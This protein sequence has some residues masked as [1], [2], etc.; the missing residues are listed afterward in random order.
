MKT[1]HRLT[2]GRS[3]EHLR[4]LFGD[5]SAGTGSSGGGGTTAH[6]CEAFTTAV[7]GELMTGLQ[8][9]ATF[10]D[11]TTQTAVWVPGAGGSQQGQANGTNWFLSEIGDTQTGT[12]TLSNT[13]GQGITKLEIVGGDVGGEVIFDTTLGSGKTPGSGA[14]QTF[15]VTGGTSVATVSYAYS[16]LVA[17]P[18]SAPVGDLFTTLTINFTSGGGLLTGTTLEF[19]A[20]TDLCVDYGAFGP[21]ETPILI[22]HVESELRTT[23]VMDGIGICAADVGYSAWG[24][25]IDSKDLATYS[26]TGYL[27]DVCYP[28]TSGTGRTTV[29]INHSAS[30][31]FCKGRGFLQGNFNFFTRTGQYTYAVFFRNASGHFPF[32]NDGTPGSSGLAIGFGNPSLDSAGSA[33]PTYIIGV[34]DGV[35][36]ETGPQLTALTGLLVVTYDGHASGA[37]NYYLA[38][39]NAIAPGYTIT[40]AGPF[41]NLGIDAAGG[42]AMG[43]TY[44]NSD[45]N[46]T[47]SDTN[48]AGL[49][50]CEAAIWSGLLNNTD[51]TNLAVRCR[52]YWGFG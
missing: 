30:V 20:D 18:S 32:I 17:L 21:V 22:W 44:G 8:V 10:A 1:R 4:L 39:F 24:D 42:F 41:N 36:T 45:P 51:I 7:N 33:P 49:D 5:V 6:A 31:I 28:S 29:T 34:K 12:W 16:G 23:T 27:A 38:V 52:D 50:F 26:I 11:T 40:T 9:T 25:L 47:V 13:T 46:R 15:T 35:A 19:K 3:F 37:T 43:G 14:G 2:K 48:A